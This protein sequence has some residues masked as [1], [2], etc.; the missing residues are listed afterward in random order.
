MDDADALSLDGSA[1]AFDEPV[2][3]DIGGN[4]SNP[5]SVAEKAAE[6]SGKGP[7][8][9]GLSTSLAHAALQSFPEERSEDDLD[10]IYQY[11]VH[12]RRTGRPQAETCCARARRGDGYPRPM[13]TRYSHAAWRGVAACVD[14]AARPA[15]L[16][17][18][19]P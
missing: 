15:Q 7:Q 10:L 11:L 12:V 14:V 18:A 5:L 16:C 3:L 2:S 13:P 9:D 1:D 6:A 19:S 4:R 17:H 8:K